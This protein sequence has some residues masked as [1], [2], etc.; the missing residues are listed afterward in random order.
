MPKNQKTESILAPATPKVS[1]AFPYRWKTVKNRPA[2]PVSGAAELQF[3]RGGPTALAF[4]GSWQKIRGRPKHTQP[5][6]L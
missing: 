2:E 1:V 5:T 6:P 4:I 3:R